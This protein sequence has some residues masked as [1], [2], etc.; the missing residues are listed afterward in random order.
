M[1]R[2]ARRA[3]TIQE[4]DERLTTVERELAQVVST[5]TTMNREA[6]DEA[7][8]FRDA[9]VEHR[10]EVRKGF[11]DVQADVKTLQADVT[12][13]RSDV[14]EILRRVGNGHDRGGSA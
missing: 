13:I 9:F 5:V 10:A 7:K 4:L 3:P 14:A 8:R 1:A 6:T 12:A 2:S 11:A